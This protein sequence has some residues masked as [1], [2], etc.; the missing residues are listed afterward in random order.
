M[1][2]FNDFSISLL[3]FCPNNVVMDFLLEY[4]KGIFFCYAIGLSNKF[5]MLFQFK[6]IIYSIEVLETISH[7]KHLVVNI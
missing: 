3:L 6:A 7:V 2:E 5:D 1:G 4:F